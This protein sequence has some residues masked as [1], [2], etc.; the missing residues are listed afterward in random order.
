MNDA[1][2]TVQRYLAAWNE[3]DPARRAARVAETW[4]ASARCGWALK[5]PDGATIARGTGRLKGARP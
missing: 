1:T 4:I 5:S 3:T 2:P